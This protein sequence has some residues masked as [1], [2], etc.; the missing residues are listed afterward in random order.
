MNFREQAVQF[1]KTAQTRRRAPIS[2]ATARKYEAS[3]NHTYSLF[4]NRD[5]SEINNG[6]LKV[7]VAKLTSE[8]LSASIVTSVVSVVK[9]V[10]ASAVNEQGDEL[11]PRTW[12]HEFIDLPILSPI[13]Q[14]APRIGGEAISQAISRAKGQDKALC[15]LLA[16]TGLRIGEAQALFVGPENSV[17]ST[18]DPETATIHVRTTVIE[19]SLIQSNPKTKAGIRDVDLAPELNEFLKTTLQPVIGARMFTNTEGDVICRQRV[20][21][22]L[23]M[24][25]GFHSLRRFRVTHLNRMNCPSGLEKYW[26][27]HAMTGV[28]ERYIGF[29]SEIKARKEFAAKAG[30][31]F[32]L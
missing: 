31:G 15:A 18:W 8:G 22:R 28:H 2:V 29:G 14:K 11:Y 21:D 3:L 7:L 4:G 16:G 19:D 20:A 30:L 6:A 32:T 23:K 9:L 26:I 17:N 13:S 1:L 5:L 12:N 10:V 25:P 27:G 24:I